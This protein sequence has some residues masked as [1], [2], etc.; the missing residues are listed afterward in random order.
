M[1][2]D[3]A[4]GVNH[5]SILVSLRQFFAGLLRHHVRSVPLGPVLVALPGSLLMLAVGCLRTPERARQIVRRSER[6]LTGIDA[7][8]Q[9]GC[10]LLQQLRVAVRVAERSVGAVAGIIRRRPAEA[11]ARAAGLE[12]RARRSGVKHLADIASVS[13]QFAARRLD[14][15]DDEV[16]ALCRAGRG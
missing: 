10:D 3:V 11:A 7:P 6:S 14:V 15:G 16:K 4:Y 13:D 8:R 9:P 1:P 12:L 5:H 2:I